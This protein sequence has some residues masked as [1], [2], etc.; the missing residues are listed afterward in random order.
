V[1]KDQL[2]PAPA[3]EIPA[4]EPD[5]GSD[6]AGRTVSGSHPSQFSGGRGRFGRDSECV[7][8]LLERGTVEAVG[9]H[10]K[11]DPAV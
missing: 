10:I 11:H 3:I 5:V 9:R 4:A 7:V 1:L 8:E 2:Q 6:R